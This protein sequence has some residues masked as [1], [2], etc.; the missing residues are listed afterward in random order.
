MMARNF[1]FFEKIILVIGII[2]VVLGYFMIQKAFVASGSVTSWDSVS[3]VFI[4]ILVI[5]LIILLAANENM[6][7][8]LKGISLNQ[9]R[10]LKLI[11]Q[12]LRYLQSKRK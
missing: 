6:K 10:E 11:K 4:W 7:E 3:T 8:E 12:E 1:N 2:I 5:L 9:T